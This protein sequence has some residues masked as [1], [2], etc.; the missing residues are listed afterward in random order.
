MNNF[1]FSCL[2]LNVTSLFGVFF[3]KNLATLLLK[4]YQILAEP[5]TFID[6]I[7]TKILQYSKKEYMYILFISGNP[8]LSL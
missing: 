6:M 4:L 7:S 2:N 3:I 8:A 5:Y 1:Y